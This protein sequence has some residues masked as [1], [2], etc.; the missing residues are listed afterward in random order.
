M[1]ELS[2]CECSGGAKEYSDNWRLQS[3]P[4][5]TMPIEHDS[6][7]HNW[8]GPCSRALLCVHCSR[9]L[10]SFQVA[11][12]KLLQFSYFSVD[13]YFVLSFIFGLRICFSP[14][15]PLHMSSQLCW[16]LSVEVL[17][18]SRRETRLINEPERAQAQ[19]R[20]EEESNFFLRR[21]S[22]SRRLWVWHT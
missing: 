5:I 3:Q 8:N 6:E 12:F 11:F 1:H 20:S 22:H 17:S 13:I 2:S 18:A 16:L 7:I 19:G 14:L 9:S 21:L 15:L 10:F 4:L